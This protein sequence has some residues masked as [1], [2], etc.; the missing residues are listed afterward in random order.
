MAHVK[1][2]PR[3]TAFCR[4]NGFAFDGVEQIR[5]HAPLITDARMVR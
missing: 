4:R 5:P 3:A 2:N 1:Q